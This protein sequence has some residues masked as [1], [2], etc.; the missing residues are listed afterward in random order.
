MGD[1][2]ND[3]RWGEDRQ[4]VGDT[5]IIIIIIMVVVHIKNEIREK[6]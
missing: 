5:I 3:R 1:N 6:E 4:S 2:N